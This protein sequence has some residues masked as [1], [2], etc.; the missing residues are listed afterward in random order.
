MPLGT[1]GIQASNQEW[2]ERRV[3]E[4]VCET[5]S[6]WPGNTET[7]EREEEAGSFFP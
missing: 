2:S 3:T 6:P 1:G 7:E 5:Q 4:G